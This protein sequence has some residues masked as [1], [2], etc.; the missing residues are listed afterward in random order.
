M[1]DD[2]LVDS[3]STHH[4]PTYDGREGYHKILARLL[5]FQKLKM[6]EGDHEGTYRGLRSW[7][8][9]CKPYI[10]KEE[11]DKLLKRLDKVSSAIIASRRAKDPNALSFFSQTIERDLLLIEEK[12]HEITA[13]VFLPRK[14]ADVNRWDDDE[15]LRE[16]NA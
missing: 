14:E 2:P 8:N 1:S 5:Y 11:S 15:F 6:I 10:N 4:K 7:F 12:A 16:S 3:E 9:M 13:D